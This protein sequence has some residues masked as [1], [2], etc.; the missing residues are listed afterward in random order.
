MPAKVYTS[1]WGPQSVEKGT[2]NVFRAFGTVIVWHILAK[3]E[4]IKISQEITKKKKKKNQLLILEMSGKILHTG[5]I[6]LLFQDVS[7]LWK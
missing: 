1:Y 2:W 3:G 7:M 4:I 6:S 5:V